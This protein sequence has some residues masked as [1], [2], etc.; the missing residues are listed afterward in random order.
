MSKKP[1]QQYRPFQSNKG[2][3][4]VTLY[5]DMLDSK[6]WEQ[7]TAND[8]KLYLAMLKKF[9]IKYVN[10]MVDKSNEDNV[11]MTKE[12]YLEIMGRGTFEKCIDHL[13]DIGF[14]KVIQY[15]YANGNR[16]TLIYGFN[17]IWRYYGTDKFKIKSEWKRLCNRNKE[18]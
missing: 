6:A 1:L 13:I 7:L 15:K 4:F 3:H 2:G 11:E 18:N 5:D 12:Q 16:K 17:D 14:I 8:I 10:G 9:R